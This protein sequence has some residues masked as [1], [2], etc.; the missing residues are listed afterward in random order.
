MLQKNKTTQRRGRDV[1]LNKVV[2]IEIIQKV[3][4][5][6]RP[7]RDEEVTLVDI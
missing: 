3:M 7:E 4:F 6:Q 1:I 5:E 2:R